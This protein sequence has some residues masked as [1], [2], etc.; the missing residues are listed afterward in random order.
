[1]FRHM[2]GDR[3]TLREY[4]GRFPRLVVTGQE[5]EEALSHEVLAEEARPA[6]SGEASP[7]ETPRQIGRY[8]V[9]RLLGTGAFGRVYLAQDDQLN[10]R[11]AIKV[12]HRRLVTQPEDAAAYLTEARNV[13]QLDHP[14]IVPVYDVGSTAECPCFIVSKF[15]EGCTLAEKIKEARP[16]VTESSSWV[17]TVA[18]ALHH[19]HRKGLVHRDIKPGNILLDTSSQPYV[20]D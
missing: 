17:A 18:E 19:A 2:L 15:I 12:P 11:V 6:T 20:A 13:A 10:R 5:I 14:N 7:T 8:R 9:E 1:R 3:L 4:R 16:T